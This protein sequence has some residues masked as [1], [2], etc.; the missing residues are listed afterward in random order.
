MSQDIE[1]V[2]KE[3]VDLKIPKVWLMN[4]YPSLKS[5]GAYVKDLQQRIQFVQ[6]I[7]VHETHNNATRT[8]NDDKDVDDGTTTT[9]NHHSFS[10]QLINFI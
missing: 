5:L 9:T 10:Q 8:R 4:S 1:T 6:V 2:A 3:I 7:V